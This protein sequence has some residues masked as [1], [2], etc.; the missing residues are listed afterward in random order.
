MIRLQ[1][2]IRIEKTPFGRLYDGRCVDRYR[3][4][5]ESGAW[6]DVSNLGATLL[7]INVPDRRGLVSDIT[8]G[9]DNPSQYLADNSYFGG[10]IGRFANRISNSK[11]MIDRRYFELSDN[12][13]PHSLHG[14]KVGFNRRVWASRIVRSASSEFLELEMCSVHGDQGYPGNLQVKCCISFDNQNRLAID[15]SAETDMTTIIN[16]THHPYFNLDGQGAGHIRDHYLSIPANFYL[17]VDNE[18]IPTGEMLE[19]SGPMD[20]RKPKMLGEG[21]N[22]DEPQLLSA[23]GYDHNWVLNCLSPCSGLHLAANLYSKKTGRVLTIKT[24]QPGIQFYSGN[25]LSDSILGKNDASYQRHAGLALE[26]QHFPDSPNQPSFP[27]TL[28]VPGEIYRSRTEWYFDTD[29][30]SNTY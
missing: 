21:L 9:F 11:M 23:S 8:L 5:N 12:D 6:I 19:V 3:I 30:S 16:L 4:T 1:D 17:P 18:L 26:T 27:S 14:G 10:I 2:G 28:L 15:Y 24:D 25:S 13:G 29:V 22:S 20:F 7:S